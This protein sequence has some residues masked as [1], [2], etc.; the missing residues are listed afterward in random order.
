MDDYDTFDID[1]VP[2]HSEFPIDEEDEIIL[3]EEKVEDMEI[4]DYSKTIVEMN[5]KEKITIPYMT[6]YERT[7]LIGIRAQQIATGATPLVDVEG[8]KDTAQIAEKELMERKI[9][10]I[11]R[12]YL[13]NRTFEDWK[14]DEL[15]IE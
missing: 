13:P 7:S 15:I 14:I 10:L 11:V 8:L 5:N 9:P 6:K 1:E 4:M 12:R 3:E 2:D